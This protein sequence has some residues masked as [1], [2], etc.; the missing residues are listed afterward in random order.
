M[1]FKRA[2]IV[3][4][5]LKISLLMLTTYSA[6]A[7]VWTVSPTTQTKSIKQALET[8]H[9]GDTI[10]IL[11]GTYKEG[12]III[13]KPITLFGEDFPIL[14]GELKNEVISIKSNDVTIKGL[15]L[16]NS[17]RMVMSD[18]GAVKVYDSKNIIIEQNILLNNYFG[19]Y[20]QYSNHC[21]IKNNIIKATQK[22]ENQSG[23]G[24]HCWKS[25][26]IQII[27]N[28][29]VGHRDGIYFEF[30][31]NSVIWRNRSIN[32][33]RYGLHFMFSNDNTYISNYFRSN[34]AGVAVMYS[35]KVTMIHNTI[36][37]NWGDAAYGILFKELSDCYLSGNIF[38]RN[39]TGIL[40]DGC[41]R[42]LLEHNTFQ[43]N[44]W[45]IR[46]QASSIDNRLEKNN[47]I[48]NTFD[49]T[50]NGTLTLNHFSENYWDKYEG[51]DLDKDKIGDVPYHPL[52]L[53]A[54]IIEK[55]PPAM[56]LYRSFM[57]SLLD[58]SEKLIPSLTP[59]NFI[60]KSPKMI[61]N[62]I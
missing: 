41:S 42:T 29:I 24:I 32:N 23:N 61:P 7:T 50:T 55:N 1:I 15:Q 8:A 35:K 57:I 60:D 38:K 27:G 56:L 54:V 25:D 5:F 11:K 9:A 44:G 22:A 6:N 37:E 43:A 52:S 16:Q 58:K 39:T 17:G 13:D 26:S 12:N 45:A 19:I 2:I 30:V 49:A 31:K 20:L 53:Y 34:G 36:E 28:K 48:G 62:K 46:L 14:D 4:I 47:F 40:F 10:H 21:I 59:E 18:P 51:Y 33:L 3:F